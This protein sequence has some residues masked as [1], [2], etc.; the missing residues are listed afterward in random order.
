[1]AEALHVPKVNMEGSVAHLL[2]A[3]PKGV[4]GP[5]PPLRCASKN[6]C[7]TFHYSVHVRLWF[8]MHHE[9][10]YACPQAARSSQ[11]PI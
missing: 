3:L 8:L 5:S 9:C 1:M 10:R 2:R 4:R 11:S 7:D 6:M